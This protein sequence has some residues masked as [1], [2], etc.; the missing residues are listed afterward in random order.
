VI[1]IRVLVCL[2]CNRLSYKEATLFLLSWKTTLQTWL[3]TGK[4]SR[5]L[6]GVTG[7]VLE[8][9]RI[10]ESYRCIYSSATRISGTFVYTS[11][12]FPSFFLA[13]SLVGRLVL[14]IIACIESN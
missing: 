3:T 10:T 11:G 8:D 1:V 6:G 4:S 5:G 9:L 14:F 12:S 2:V 13:W 7:L